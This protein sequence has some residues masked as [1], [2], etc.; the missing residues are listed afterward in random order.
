MSDHGPQGDPP[1][2]GG[3]ASN[4]QDPQ[5]EPSMAEVLASIRRIINVDGE[6]PVDTVAG[7]DSRPVSIADNDTSKVMAADLS[8]S[9]AK[10]LPE[11]QTIGTA[12]NNDVL[13]LT[14]E[15]TEEVL[16]PPATV[17]DQSVGDDR[18]LSE[19]SAAAALS[20][21]AILPVTAEPRSTLPMGQSDQTLEDIVKELLRPMLKEWLDE[22]LPG[23]VER[24][25]KSEIRR[26]R[27]D[28][29]G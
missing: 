17:S 13:E 6:S 10:N 1:A 15:L 16:P 18:L 3:A 11:E 24:I 8:Q 5:T 28:L 29:D 4:D 20:A 25:V 2:T 26:L 7:V 14:E 9:G 12:S 19:S 27:D 23:T 21:L 22:N